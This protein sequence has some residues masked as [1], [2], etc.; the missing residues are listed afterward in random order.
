MRIDLVAIQLLNHPLRLIQRQE[1]RDANT[2]KRRHIGVLELRV[3]FS[4]GGA[5][6]FHAL[7][8]V[9]E[10]LAAGEAAARADDGVEHGAELRA[11]LGELGEGFLEDG[12]ELQEA[13]GVAGGRGVEDDDFVGEGFDLLED[14]G[15]GHGFVDAGDLWA[16]RECVS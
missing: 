15:E 16:I 14:F 13:E 9:V 5:Q 7:D 3:N 1:F 8:Q 4:D 2:H 11:E 6:A 10:I 12:G